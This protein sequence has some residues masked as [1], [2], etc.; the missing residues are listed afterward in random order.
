VHLRPDSYHR[1]ATRAEVVQR[2][3]KS[4]NVFRVA[5]LNMFR[6]TAGNAQSGWLAFVLAH[7]TASPDGKERAAEWSAHMYAEDAAKETGLSIQS[8]REAITACVEFG[9]TPRKAETGPDSHRYRVDMAALAK[10]PRRFEVR[11]GAFCPRKPIVSEGEE[12]EN[13]VED[14]EACGK[15]HTIAM[16]GDRVELPAGERV[17]VADVQE[18]G[19]VQILSSSA[20]S[21]KATL[22]KSG[23]VRIEVFPFAPAKPESEDAVLQP[24]GLFRDDPRAGEI[25]AGLASLK[26]PIY[27]DRSMASQAARALNAPVEFF[28]D[29]AAERVERAI[30]SRTPINSGLV[31]LMVSDVNQKWQ[32]A[33]PAKRAQYEG[34]QEQQRK[35]AEIERYN[36]LDRAADTLKRGLA[37]LKTDLG[38]DALAVQHWACCLK[39]IR[40]AAGDSDPKLAQWAR[41]VLRAAGESVDDSPVK[42]RKRA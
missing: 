31:L 17:Q 42:R 23:G 28:L 2:Y 29:H 27:L 9:L 12:K 3:A 5:I 8:M 26:Q 4:Q 22:P 38:D 39:Y 33:A 35:A 32:I 6:A 40:R 7:T 15:S 20:C 37:L 36:N 10:A 11:A 13:E 14:S 1:K 41:E 30:A 25:S 19:P 21:I 34:L 18:P 16:A 24:P